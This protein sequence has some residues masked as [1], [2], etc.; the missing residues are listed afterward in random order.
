MPDYE[1]RIRQVID[2]AQTAEAAPPDS[3]VDVRTQ[4]PKSIYDHGSGAY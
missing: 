3:G 4:L 1:D 2:D